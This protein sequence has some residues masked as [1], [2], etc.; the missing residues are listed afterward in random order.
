LARWDNEAVQTWSLQ[1]HLEYS[2]SFWNPTSTSFYVSLVGFLEIKS[3]GYHI[4]SMDDFQRV[5]VSG[6]YLEFGIWKLLLGFGFYASPPCSLLFCGILFGSLNPISAR[7]FP[8]LSILNAWDMLL[9][10]YLGLDV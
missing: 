5:L 6:I 7:I 4:L 10:F 8:W 1:W 3:V 2:Q 9:W